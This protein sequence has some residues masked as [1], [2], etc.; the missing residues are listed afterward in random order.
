MMHLNLKAILQC[1]QTQPYLSEPLIPI[2]M[3]PETWSLT[4]FPTKPS[5]VEMFFEARDFVQRCKDRKPK[6]L[7]ISGP[8]GIGKTTT[9]R[10]V[11]QDLKSDKQ[12]TIQ[13]ID[14]NSSLI[15]NMPY[16]G[17]T[18]DDSLLKLL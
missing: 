5:Q 15:V 4:H 16:H 6:F 9:M 18:F 2:H 17:K 7:H 3:S 8:P 11:L 12:Q 14:H 13:W 1:F 10:L